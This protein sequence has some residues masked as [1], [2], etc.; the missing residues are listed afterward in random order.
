MLHRPCGAQIFHP[1]IRWLSPPATS[2]RLRRSSYFHLPRPST[3]TLDSRHSPK[4]FPC[5]G[6]HASLSAATTTGVA[7]CL[8]RPRCAFPIIVCSS[9]RTAARGASAPARW[10]RPTRPTTS[11]CAWSSRSRSSR[12]RRWTIRPRRPSSCARPAPPRACAIP[13]S[14]ACC[15]STTRREIFSTRWN[16]WRAGRCRTCCA[17]TVRCR[18]PPRFPSRRR[19]RAA[20]PRFTPAESSIAISSRPTSC[21]CPASSSAAGKRTGEAPEAWQV[22]VIDFGLARTFF[23]DALGDESAVHTVGFRGTVLYASPEQ[24]EE[25]D[26]SR[27]PFRSIFAR[28]HPVGNAARRAAVRREIACRDDEPRHAPAAARATRRPAGGRA[29]RDGANAGEGTGA[30]LSRCGGA[31]TRTRGMPPPDRNRRRSHGHPRRAAGRRRQRAAP[32]IVDARSIDRG[33]AREHWH[34]RTGPP[35]GARGDRR[36]LAHRD[37]RGGRLALGPRASNSACGRPAIISAPPAARSPEPIPRTQL[38]IPEKSIAVLPFDNLS[39]DKQS[40][41]FASGMQDEILT[42]LAKVED[43]KVISRSSVMQYKGDAPAQPARDRT[44]A[45]RRAHSRGQR[46]ARGRSRDASTPNSS[47]CAP[48]RKSGPS[49]T[50][51]T[52]RTSSP[53]RRKFPRR[54]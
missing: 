3:S 21:S 52:W 19:R 37:Q 40:E 2:S 54:L 15:T 27:R 12:R 25:R 16:S 8:S 23:G 7:L 26:R 13:T 29:G 30:P 42:D 4:G 43:L 28:L 10:A 39:E 9:T 1:W 50:S 17:S 33:L 6:D 35:T 14:P 47:T 20:S 48:T 11:D 32:V 49:A 41:Y 45:R 5:R 18:P 34:G 24:C 31:G 51:G 38:P 44:V 22:K 46:A 53:S 36:D